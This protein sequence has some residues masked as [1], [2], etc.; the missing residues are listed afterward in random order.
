[1]QSLCG[2]EGVDLCLLT[3]VVPR[4]CEVLA[5]LRLG[6]KA[7]ALS[8]AFPA[9]SEPEELVLLSYRLSMYEKQTFS[10]RMRL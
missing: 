2:V 9:L 1:M 3:C 7:K 10:D 8:E 6:C 5:G 4:V